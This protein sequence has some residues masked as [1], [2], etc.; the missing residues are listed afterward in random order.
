MTD[1]AAVANTKFLAPAEPR[2]SRRT[3]AAQS[4]G[5]AEAGACQAANATQSPIEKFPRIGVIVTPVAQPEKQGRAIDR[6]E[7]QDRKRRLRLARI[8]C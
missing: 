8:R 6:G 2:P 4:S 5:G 7:P 1:F 3:Q